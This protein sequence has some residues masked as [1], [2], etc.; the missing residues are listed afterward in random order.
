MNSSFHEIRDKQ[1]DSWNKFSTGWKK[2]N[3]EL[4]QHMQPATEAILNYLKPEDNQNILDIASGAGEP[5]ISIAKKINNGNVMLTDLA[6][7][8]LSVA[9][10]NVLHQN[11]KNISFQV[12]DVCALPFSDNSFDK[13]SCRMG[14]M[15]FP[16]LH[17]ATKEIYRVLKPGG[18]FATTVWTTPEKNFWVTAIGDVIRKNMQLPDVSI[19]SEKPS[20]FR[21][22]ESGL[23]K[24]FFASAG[25]K[26]IQEKEIVCLLHCGTAERYWEM[27][28]EIAAPVVGVLSKADNELKEKIKQE[29]ITL[30]HSKYPEGNIVLEGSALVIYGEK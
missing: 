29:V 18:G 16:D 2:W 3:K 12:C 22:A 10:E 27:M 1:K 15:F 4:L 19:S 14:Y 24:N 11:I 9:Q 26:N 20:I 8:M 6:A 30:I 7:D 25:F 13:V 21:C 28:N 5:G 17:L 23:M